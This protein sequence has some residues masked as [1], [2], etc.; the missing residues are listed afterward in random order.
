MK[1]IQKY[2]YILFMMLLCS[3]F[4]LFWVMKHSQPNDFIEI[5]ISEGD[6]LWGL[7]EHFSEHEEPRQWIRKVIDMNDLSST[8]IKSGET[9]KLPVYANYDANAIVLAGEER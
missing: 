4:T 6:T 9:L 3:T 5:T 2:G 7:A 8:T 1:F